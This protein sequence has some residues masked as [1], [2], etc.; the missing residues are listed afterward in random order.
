MAT[1]R[2]PTT[3]RRGAARPPRK[4]RSTSRCATGAGATASPSSL[5]WV[6]GHRAVR[7]RRR[8]SSS[9]WRSRG[10]STCSLDAALPRD[11]QPAARPVEDRRL[12]RPDPRHGPA[13]GHRHRRSRRRSRVGDRDLDRRVRPARRAGA[14]RRVGD[15]DR[16]RARPTS[17]IAIFGLALFQQGIFGWMSFTAEGG[18]V[19][20]R[21]FLTAGAMMSLIALPMVFG[22]TRE[23]LQAIPRT[24]ARRP[25]ASARRRSRRSAASCCRRCGRTSPPARRSAWAASPATRRSSSILLGATLRLDAEGVDPGRRRAPRH[26]LDADELRLQQLARRRGQRAGEGLRRRVRAAAD[27]HRPELRRRRDRPARRQTGSSPRGWAHDRRRPRTPRG[28]DADADAR[29]RAG[30][31]RWRRRC[32]RIV[33]DRRRRSPRR[34]C[35]DHG[36]DARAR[37]AGPERMTLDEPQRRSTAASR[38]SRSVSL[39]IR[40]GEVLALIGPSGCGKTTL[41]RTLNRL[42]ELTPSARRDGHDRCSTARTSTRSRSPSCAAACRWSSSSPTRSRCRSSTTSP[43][44]CASR[45]RKR[46]GKAVLEP[47]VERRAAARRPVGRG[48]ATTSTARRCASPAASSSGC[49]SRA[50]IATRP[51]VLLM[52]EPCSALDPR[53]T[54]VIEELIGELRHELADRDRH[55]QPRSRRTASATSVAFMYLGDLVEY[56]AGRAG[57]RRAARP[58]HARLR[59]RG[60]R[61]MRA[62]ARAAAV[63]GRA[64]AVGLRDDAGQERAAAPSGARSSLNAEGADGRRANPDVQVRRDARCV[65]DANGV[66]AV[67]ELRNRGTAAQAGAAGRDRR[68]RRQAARGST[69]TTSPASSRRC[70]SLPLLA[71]G[72]RGLLGQQPDLAGGQAAPRSTAKVGAAKGAAPAQVPRPSPSRGV[73]LGRRQRRRLRHGHRS[74]TARRSSR[75]A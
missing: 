39:P 4:R 20:G 64:G 70:V 41:L 57:L 6:A 59:R 49:A 44:R 18:A 53:S 50:R 63:A 3:A 52:D 8:R 66:A 22:A 27:R 2:T 29:R 43:T 38:P 25:T 58:A 14:R 15:R 17:C 60:V 33:V 37:R 30:R 65:Q 16:R 1:P 75:S 23:G 21:S 32:A 35:A 45:R 56:G 48:R 47:L 54:A 11:P 9:T 13:D 71:P 12:P 34:P 55:P 68:P 26:R 62:R 69:A 42:T 31:P 74:P 24:C 72:E 28:P 10:C 19:F 7:D 73:A 46:P 5:C 67:V 40:Q 61:V 51:E 36:R